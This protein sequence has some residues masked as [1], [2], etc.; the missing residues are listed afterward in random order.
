MQ[1]SEDDIKGAVG[2]LYPFQYDVVRHPIRSLGQFLIN[3]DDYVT[4]L[5]SP[6]KGSPIEKLNAFE[7]IIFNFIFSEIF[8]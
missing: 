7:G 2:A 3:V 8:I 5:C 4:E 1:F 6:K